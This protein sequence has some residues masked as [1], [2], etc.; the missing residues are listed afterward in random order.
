TPAVS[1]GALFDNVPTAPAVLK[2]TLAHGRQV[3]A[4]NGGESYVIGLQL[5]DNRGAVVSFVRRPELQA[6]LGIVR[7]Q[8]VRSA[9][10]A[11]VIGALVGLLIASLITARLRRIA[12]SA[13]E[14]EAGA[15]DRPLAPSFPDELGALAETID[16][17][18]VRLRG[19]FRDLEAERDRLRQLL[20]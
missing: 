7:A 17:M 18:R 4:I 1:R 6:Q 9:L 16:Q 8:I 2:A 10:F 14:I 5:R 13:A 19:S 15:F 12:R 20:E 3:R 11:V